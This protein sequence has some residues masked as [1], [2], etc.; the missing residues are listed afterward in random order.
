VRPEFG[1][2]DQSRPDEAVKILASRIGDL[3]REAIDDE[4]LLQLSGWGKRLSDLGIAPGASGNLSMRVDDGFLITRTEVELGSIEPDDWVLVTRLDRRD[5][6][7]L[8][9]TFYGDHPPSRDSFVHGTVYA[10]VPTA[11]AVF[12]LHDRGILAKAGRLGVPS[13]DHY[14][15][16][17]TSESVAEIERLLV[18]FPTVDYFV[19][20]EHGIVAWASDIEAAG[21]L[22]ERWHH[23]AKKAND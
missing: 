23:L 14:Y 12:H 6:G 1:G 11:D 20:V 2:P 13:T 21:D 7:T 3:P 22:V 4:R 10:R 16:A 18:R 9:V 19:L 5:D 8:E 17:G 15:P